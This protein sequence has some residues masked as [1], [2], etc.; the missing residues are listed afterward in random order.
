MTGHAETA[1]RA[2]GSMESGG[3][4]HQAFAMADREAKFRV[5]IEGV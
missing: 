4:D 5:E 3:T 2:Q 1:P